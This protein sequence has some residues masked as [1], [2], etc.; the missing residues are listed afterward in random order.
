[1]RLTTVNPPDP[2]RARRLNDAIRAAAGKAPW[3]T[4]VATKGISRSDAD[5]RRAG[6]AA[7]KA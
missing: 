1:M 2:A 5:R 6:V 7:V 4:R 3:P